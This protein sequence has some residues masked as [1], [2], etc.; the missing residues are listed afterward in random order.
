MQRALLESRI[1]FTTLLKVISTVWDEDVN[2]SLGRPGGRVNLD[3][4]GDTDWMKFFLYGHITLIYI[5]TH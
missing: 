4:L 3:D 5:P 1:R 2:D